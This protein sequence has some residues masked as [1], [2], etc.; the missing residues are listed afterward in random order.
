M[1]CQHI[2]IEVSI[3][4]PSSVWNSYRNRLSCGYARLFYDPLRKPCSIIKIFVLSLV[5]L[6]E[7]FFLSKDQFVRLSEFIC[8][9]LCDEQVEVC[10]LLFSLILASI[11]TIDHSCPVEIR[12]TLV[13]YDIWQMIC[14]FLAVIHRSATKLPAL[15]P[16]T[17]GLAMTITSKIWS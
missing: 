1:F 12:A 13:R 16:I 4:I 10:V 17:H 8:Q 9:K 11:R 6:H 15:S 2:E 3:C 14:G 7:L 5:L